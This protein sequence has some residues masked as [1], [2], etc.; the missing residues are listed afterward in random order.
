MTAF[1][2]DIT[3]SLTDL[4]AVGGSG[5]DFTR[6][7]SVS[8]QAISVVETVTG[9]FFQADYREVYTSVSDAAWLRKAAAYQTLF[10][11]EN[12]DILSRTAVSSLSQDGI[13]V[14][15]P[16][17][18]TFVLAPLAKRALNNCSWAKTGTLKVAPS[19]EVDVVSPLVS[20]DHAWYP[21]G[22]I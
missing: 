22:A 8:P 12:E 21:L 3:L 18:L 15:A 7:D 6:F 2:T 9:V 4:Q 5:V 11:L 19:A 16:D 14:S 1:T 17:S 10:M 13:S 20:D